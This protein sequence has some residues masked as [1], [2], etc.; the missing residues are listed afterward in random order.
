MSRAACKAD[1]EGS[2]LVHMASL[3]WS[4]RDVGCEDRGDDSEDWGW[5]W[6]SDDVIVFDE[7]RGGLDPEGGEV[8]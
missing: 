2:T 6:G 3:I 7:D 4:S 1:I 5:S 8:D